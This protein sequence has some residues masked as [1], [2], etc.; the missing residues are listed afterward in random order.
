MP[1]DELGAGYHRLVGDFPAVQ[2]REDTVDAN[3]ATVDGG[4]ADERAVV[5]LSAKEK[6][7]VTSAPG[8]CRLGARRSAGVEYPPV[9]KSSLR[10]VSRSVFFI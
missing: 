3:R 1:A 8:L 10:N 7:A 5:A 9:S 2:G 6:R 4:V